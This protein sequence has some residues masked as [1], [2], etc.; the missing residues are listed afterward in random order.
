MFGINDLT[1]IQEQL[2]GCTV[3]NFDSAVNLNLWKD[4]P[5]SEIVLE[6]TGVTKPLVET[7]LLLVVCGLEAEVIRSNEAIVLVLEEAS[8]ANA[9]TACLP[10]CNDSTRQ[11]GFA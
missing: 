9:L 2:L 4:T 1:T 10:F 5:C 8:N 7:L 6:Q 11:L 3:L